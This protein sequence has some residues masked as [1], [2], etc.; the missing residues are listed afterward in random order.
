M[1]R[2]I[3][4][5]SQKGGVG[6]TTTVVNL[7]AWLALIGK[8]VLIID[9]D[10]QRNA[11]HCL[12]LD[13]D[14]LNRGLKEVLFKQHPIDMAVYKTFIKNLDIVP[15]N[16]I[17][18][19]T[20]KSLIKNISEDEYLLRDS[21]DRM[22]Q[23]YDFIFIDCPPANL[24]LLILAITAADSVILPLQCEYMALSSM[25]KFLDTLTYVKEHFNKWIKLEGILITMYEENTIYGR[26]IVQEA[27]TQF[28]SLLFNTI[29]PKNSRLSEASSLGRPV[30][31]YDIKSKGSEAYL[32]FAKELTQRYSKKIF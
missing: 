16:I 5:A 26:V 3:T 12:G 28:N 30:V 2:V 22:E 8:K 9:L 10:S 20:E 19:E 4:I 25:T 18:I 23:S 14:N 7:G 27:K 11:G 32:S 15:S 31:L 17:D 13:Q 29:I 1:N 21:L 24:S 6:K